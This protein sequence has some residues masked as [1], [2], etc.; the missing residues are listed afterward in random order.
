MKINCDWSEWKEVRE[1]LGLQP[2][3]EIY[4]KKNVDSFANET[5]AKEERKI[6]TDLA[7]GI[8]IDESDFKNKV[9]NVDGFLVHENNL[10]LVYIRDNTY[11][12]KN[13]AMIKENPD[14]ANKFHI[15]W[16]KTMRKMDSIKRLNNRYV[17]T[18]RDD[19]L[20]PIETNDE[21]GIDVGTYMAKLNVC[22]YCLDE[23][24]YHGY[25]R[26]LPK[27]QREK[28]VA[29][30]NIKEF[31]EEVGN[32]K[33]YKKEPTKTADIKATSYY[34][35]NNAEIAK[36]LKEKKQYECED[37]KVLLREAGHRQYLQMHHL[38]LDKTDN[39]PHNLK[40]LCIDCHINSY[41]TDT[42]WG[43]S[44]ASEIAACRKIKRE[45]GISVD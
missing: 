19:G 41:H 6:L 43:K 31:F 24:K 17:M 2:N 23:A 3:D 29:D 21:Y 34:S 14:E 25:D 39:N 12:K 9:K 44:H 20:F 27:S 10:I 35:K 7:Q 33:R 42:D 4:N 40:I 5:M 38:N 36:D 18:R 15:H 13:I 1:R 32:S 8:E 45:Q 11:K 16:C 37:C 26:G 28:H 30:F 22:K